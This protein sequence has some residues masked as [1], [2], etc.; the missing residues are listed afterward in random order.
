MKRK[1]FLQFFL[2]TLLSALLMFA[3]GVVAVNV[4]AKNILR[5]RLSHETE[6]VCALMRDTSDFSAFDRYKTSG[7]FRLTVLSTD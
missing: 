2:I 7:A 4:N 1:I 6:I 3:C 5:S